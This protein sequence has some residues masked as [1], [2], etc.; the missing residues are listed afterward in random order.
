MK[1]K[2]RKKRKEKQSQTLINKSITGP[3]L[4][5]WCKFQIFSAPTLAMV[6][7]FFFFFDCSVRQLVIRQ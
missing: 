2:E 5:I 6:F 4:T 3:L 7:F 1:K